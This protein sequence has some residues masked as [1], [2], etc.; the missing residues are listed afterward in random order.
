MKKT[1]LEIYAY[2]NYGSVN[3]FAEAIN[4]SPIAIWY[5]LRKIYKPS[6]KHAKMIE[7]LTNGEITEDYLRNH[8][9]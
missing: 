7:K 3:K 5:W 6:V 9:V 8:L 4:L 2:T 1:K